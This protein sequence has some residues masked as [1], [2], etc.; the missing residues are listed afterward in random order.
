MDRSS[1]SG[2][3]SPRRRRWPWIVGGLAVLGFLG[4][5]A[6]GIALVLLA[7]TPGTTTPTTYDEE[8]VSGGGADKIA[9][10][11]VEGTIASADSSLSGPVPIATPEGLRDAL[12]QAREDESVRAVVLAVNS[13]G[14]GVTASD[15]MH[16][17]LQDFRRTTDKPVVVS[18]GD[19]AASGG[20]YISTAADRIVAN[21]TTLTGS[22]GVFIPLLNFSE[23]SERYGV[24]QIYIK[25]GRF[26]AMGNPWNELTEDERRIFQSIVD[27]YYD[28]F[29][30]VIVEGRD[31]PEK[32][33]RELADGRV[34]SGIQAERL[35][36]VDRLGN[37]D[38]AV[39]V[40]R[41]LAGLDE[42]RV[43]RY[44]Q[45]PSLLETMLA[46]L[47]PREPE[48]LQL[49]RAANLDLEAKPYYLYL[50]GA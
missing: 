45:S 26:K 34:Y 17:A 43:V 35:G 23:A 50:P 1:E 48:S 31:L 18:M 6:L 19:V 33:V 12:R 7:G 44:V 25:S 32:R 41:D 2:T 38:V 37:L 30:E 3:P 21:E 42:A 49:L 24:K 4:L 13:P 40:A 36:L 11:P 5:V 22:I 47:E 46:R 29:V 27:Q 15:L 20:Y 14:G 28:E 8:Y 39:R 16:D 9:V 10:I